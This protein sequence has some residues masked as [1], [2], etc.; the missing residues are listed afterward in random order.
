MV[1]VTLRI[2]ETTGYHHPNKIKTFTLD[3]SARLEELLIK[4]K[5][6]GSS[7]ATQSTRAYLNGQ[8]L[9]LNTSIASH[10]LEDNQLIECC[11]SPYMSA[12]LTS[13]LKD[14][15]KVQDVLSNDNDD[16]SG[17]NKDNLL[18]ILQAPVEMVDINNFWT[19]AQWK[20]DRVK[21]RSISLATIK[22]ILQ[23]MDRNSDYDLPYCT[24]VESL[25]DGLQPVWEG[26]ANVGSSR[27]SKF[28]NTVR[29]ILKP[30][31]KANGHPSTCWLLLKRKL[32]IQQDI[33]DAARR[34]GKIDDPNYDPLD[35]FIEQDDVRLKAIT[36]N[37]DSQRSGVA[38]TPTRIGRSRNS[39]PNSA[40]TTSAIEYDSQSGRVAA[41]PTRRGR[42][43]T[44]VPNSTAATNNNNNTPSSNHLTN[45]RNSTPRR[46][47]KKFY[48]PEYESGPFAVL[49]TLVEAMDPSLSS[50]TAGARRELSLTESKLKYKAQHRCRANLYDRNIG[51][52]SRNAFACMHNLSDKELVRKEIGNFGMEN[53]E[54][55]EKWSLLARGEELAKDCLEFE[56]AV[57]HTL[58]NN[59]KSKKRSN[60][61]DIILVADT[62]EDNL[63]L[64]RLKQC[65]TD[66]HVAY[67]ERELPAGDYLFMTKD[68]KIIPLIIERKSWSDLADSV[69][70]KG[71]GHRRLDCVKVGQ[72]TPNID[73]TA[74]AIF[75]K[76]Q[77]EGSHCQRKNCQLCKMKR[78]GC[79]QILFIIE[80]A[81]CNKRDGNK[82]R[83]NCTAEKRCQ[84]CKSLMDRHH[85]MNHD[86][87]E[88][89]IHRLQIQHG[90]HIHLTNSY[91]ETITSLLM[92][93]DLLLAE[94]DNYASIRYKERMSTESDN[95]DLHLESG[96]DSDQLLSY[97][98]FLSNAKNTSLPFNFY[99]QKHMDIKDWTMKSLAGKIAS[100]N[101]TWINVLHEDLALVPISVRGIATTTTTTTTTAA[102]ANE[103]REEH[104]R[105]T[106]TT[107]SISNTTTTI[108][109]NQGRKE[110]VDNSYQVNIREREVIVLDD[111]V[112]DNGR[113]KS[114]EVV[115]LDDSSVINLCE[116]QDCI[117][118]IDIQD[119]L[120]D[121]SSG[122]T[123]DCLEDTHVSSSSKPCDVEVVNG[124]D[125]DD[126]EVMNSDDSVIEVM[127]V[128]TS[129]NF[130]HTNDISIPVSCKKYLESTPLVVIK[131][132]HDYNRNFARTIEEI[133]RN[134]LYQKIDSPPSEIKGPAIEKIQEIQQEQLFPLLR[135]QP[136]LY[137]ILYLQIKL[138]VMVRVATQSKHAED[139]MQLWAKFS[140]HVIPIHVTNIQNQE[141]VQYVESIQ[142]RRQRVEE[143]QP[144]QDVE[145]MGNF[146]HSGRRGQGQPPNH[147]DNNQ[148]EARNRKRQREATKTRHTQ[149]MQ[150]VVALD[151]ENAAESGMRIKP[152]PPVN[153]HYASENSSRKR[154]KRGS[155]SSPHKN[156][157]LSSSASG[158]P[159]K[160]N[161]A[162]GNKIPSSSR[163]PRPRDQSTSH[164]SLE[165]SKAIEARL[166]RFQQSVAKINSNHENLS[167]TKMSNNSLT[168][169]CAKCTFDNPIDVTICDMCF[170]PNASSSSMTPLDDTTKIRTST[171]NSTIKCTPI[172]R[173][174][175][176]TIIT[177]GLNHIDDQNDRT[178]KVSVMR[179]GAC[180]EHGHTRRNYDA[181]ICRAFNDAGEVEKRQKDR[182]KKE[183]KAKNAREAFEVSKA[184]KDAME[185]TNEERTRQIQK[186]VE[187]MANENDLQK[188]LMEADL[189][190][191]EQAMKRT[192][193]Q[194]DRSRR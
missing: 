139:T 60:S 191:K 82:Y 155:I 53:G 71:K 118:I 147:D 112:H 92:I 132:L 129:N 97:D 78:S 96:S 57:N 76:W 141:H 117:Q 2:R 161:I 43:R 126:V 69:M 135:R 94:G 19:L 91:N 59:L 140:D 38:S 103:S 16:S 4:S 5:T 73:I 86:I 143:M 127:D 186:I 9:A 148:S 115:E 156:S 106:S 15:E 18:H 29:N 42:N 168:W 104:V 123:I 72:I 85:G 58:P 47:G 128:D 184:N 31:T 142:V 119:E 174:V 98:Q 75:Q 182:Q 48:C 81:W 20:F 157:L 33:I 68:E 183:E 21:S 79:S 90:C 105:E 120:D 108:A 190:R 93:R 35:E 22:S 113:T 63:Y 84:N 124:D 179:C 169:S 6:G 49:C 159:P 138:G 131:H 172:H 11:K 26:Q 41:T 50:N 87:L 193:K 181:S 24:T 45:S 125:S 14:L 25:Y 46:R 44:S 32:E 145:T 130:E 74:E 137:A 177:T 111:D 134:V 150:N 34:S 101:A 13:L 56:K 80:G 12:A 107:T 52:G 23:R 51:R 102:A 64:R 7:E 170:I 178:K 154:L 173:T 83:N 122:S 162:C 17:R 89:V 10:N 27:S 40:D 28:T 151:T 171:A 176:P 99:K 187:D 109:A 167:T 180:G 149:T 54:N 30:Q 36:G 116:S 95:G 66:K 194:A 188:E 37:N 189:K 67:E 39:I 100:N 65:C 8:E 166:H 152:P 160:P 175:E 164:I 133:W 77:E 165:R 121:S 192:R 146:I 144:V 136:L 55:I 110:H 158:R 62:R 3:S 185:K 114:Y 88:G 1:Q 61:D 70:G 153:E 163:Q